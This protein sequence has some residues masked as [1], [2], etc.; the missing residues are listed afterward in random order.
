MM[1]VPGLFIIEP[2]WAVKEAN[3]N[4]YQPVENGAKKIPQDLAQVHH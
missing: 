4:R 2:V 3:Y 1:A